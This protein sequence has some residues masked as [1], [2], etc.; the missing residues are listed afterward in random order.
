MPQI[1]AAQDTVTFNRTYD[2]NN[3]VE[4]GLTVLTLDDGYLIA[5]S[6]GA[7][8]FGGWRA[9]K[10]VKVD[11]LGNV[12]W[13]KLYGERG[14]ITSVGWYSGFI[15]LDDG[16]FVAAS[17][18]DS[19][20]V[21]GS[22]KLYRFDN[23][24]DTLWTKTY[25]KP[26]YDLFNSARPTSDN[27]FIIIGT[28]YNQANVPRFWLVKTDSLGVSEWDTI[29]PGSGYASTIEVTQDGGYI[30]GGAGGNNLSTARIVKTDSMGNVEWMK[31]HFTGN[32]YGCYW[33]A[34][35]ASDGGYY[36][37][38]CN[39]TVIDPTDF[40]LTATV[41]KLDNAGT[42]VW[43]NH[44]RGLNNKLIAVYQVKELSDGHIMVA[45]E[46]ATVDVPLAWGWIIKAD[47]QGNTIWEKLHVYRGDSI[48]PGAGTVY[49]FNA[50]DDGG[51]IYT[52]TGFNDINPGPNFNYN[53]D[54]WLL[55]LDSL[56]NWYVP[57][58]TTCP[59]PCDTVGITEAATLQAKLYPNPT[60][61]TLTVELPSGQGG[62]I[63][64]YNLLGQ[65]MFSSTING[66]TTLQAGLPQGVYVYR[67]T[68][69]GLEKMGRLVV[70]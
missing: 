19:G 47:L 68:Q 67:I 4:S 60:N 16:F 53:Q 13:K 20:N 48:D 39:D 9:L 42:R 26:E 35:L 37:W 40:Y 10:L 11:F 55:K 23:N 52:G 50:C 14:K 18:A 45:G 65:N 27:G 25:D 59:A 3:G 41:A 61:G 70:E 15:K 62:S 38:G 54:I 66:T 43:T 12:L 51:Y 1:C 57:P 33:A 7:S 22:G 8:E 56:G 21:N 29:M 5:G 69:G 28:S 44:Y 36:I 58:D 24:G 63:T 34:G 49:D 6:G 46:K 30:I 32:R 31:N 64:L 2:F 17:V